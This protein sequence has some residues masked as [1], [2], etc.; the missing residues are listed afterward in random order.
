MNVSVENDRVNKVSKSDLIGDLILPG[1]GVLAAGMLVGAGVTYIAEEN[2][3]PAPIFDC[4]NKRGGS[5]ELA[6]P[7]GQ[8]YSM[9][10]INGG[11]ANLEVGQNG[12]V[13]VFIKEDDGKS[14]T[15]NA[16]VTI[17]DDNAS[18]AISEMTVSGQT[19]VDVTTTCKPSK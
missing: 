11:S 19:M 15:L 5:V 16:P 9:K 18:Y 10:S 1:V 14:I 13:T 2:G 6:L 12:E 8:E 3:K 17:E 4:S 7:K